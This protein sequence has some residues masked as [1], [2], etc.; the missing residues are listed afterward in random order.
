MSVCCQASR[1]VFTCRAAS[2]GASRLCSARQDVVCIICN[3]IAA[4]L[5]AWLCCRYEDAPLGMQAIK[6]AGFLK[7]VDVTLMPEYPQLV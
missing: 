6:A 1:Q 7:A 5:R 3:D 2:P 4:C